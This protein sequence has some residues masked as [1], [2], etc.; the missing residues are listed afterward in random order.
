MFIQAK[1]RY[2]KLMNTA[3]GESVSIVG[4]LTNILNGS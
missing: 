2:V 4:R 1:G 3:R